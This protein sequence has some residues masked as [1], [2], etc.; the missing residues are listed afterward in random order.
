MAH[1]NHFRQLNNIQRLSIDE[2]I[3]LGPS[4]VSFGAFG[5]T[6]NQRNLIGLYE[7]SRNIGNKGIVLI[8]NDSDFESRLSQIYEIDPAIQQRGIPPKMYLANRSGS[9]NSFYDPLYGLSASDVLDVISPIPSDSRTLSEVQSVRSILADYLEIINY[10]F[11]KN[12]DAFGRYPYNLD[13]LYELTKMPF[14]EL[15][16]NVIS[17]LPD[18]EFRSLARRLSAVDAQQRAF[19]AVRSFAL[20]LEKCLWKSKGF[21]KHSKLSIIETVSSGNLI[22]IYVPGSRKET[23]DYLAAEFRALNDRNISYL[24]VTSNISINESAEFKK[25]FLNEHATLPYS[26]G[27]LAEDITSIINTNAGMNGNNAANNIELSAFFSQTQDIFVFSCSSTLSA[28]PFSDGIGNYYRQVSEQ[29]NDTHR[30]PFHIFSS[31]GYGVAQR[32]VR[33]AIINPEELT[34]LGD[35][36]LIYG[37]N[38]AIPILINHFTF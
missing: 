15:D 38:H 26:T 28:A 27:I 25:L 5:G 20:S 1:I 22:S 8:H 14:S 7:I 21:S 16:R 13:L 23:L 18:H 19:N 11:R 17:F 37:S 33:Q 30:E 2:A 24:L 12:N 4:N 36:C 9:Q 34:T 29:H 6:K 32:E 31:R 35:G 3:P 10:Q